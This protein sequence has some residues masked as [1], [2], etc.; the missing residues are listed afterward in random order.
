MHD[1]RDQEAHPAMPKISIS[2]PTTYTASIYDDI[3]NYSAAGATGI[4]VWEY[5]LDDDDGAVRAAMDAAGLAATIC[6]PAVP[7]LVPDPFFAE[8]ADPDARLAALITAIKRF[9]AFD[10]AAI[11]VTTGQPGDYGLAEARRIVIERLKPAADAA[12]NLGVVLGVEPYR[13]TSGTLVTTLP[14]VLELVDAVGRPNVKVIVDV[15][16]YWDIPGGLDDLAANADRVVGV[17]MNDWREPTR[18][19]CDRVLPGDGSIDLRAF[20]RTLVAA[21]WD[22]WYDIE[23]FSDNGLFGNAYQ[24][25]VW[26]RPPAEVA[27]DSVTKFMHLW[28]TMND[29]G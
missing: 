18:G 15:W 19:W 11:L 21:G 12:G 25:S 17:Q 14:E 7:S 20:L 1:P 8:P 4:G 6:C 28:N 22:G 27:R 3:E 26:S 13:Q 2:C 16:H 5:K 23:V 9:S 29:P 24:D 10:P